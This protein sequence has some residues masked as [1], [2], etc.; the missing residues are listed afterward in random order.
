MAAWAKKLRR[1]GYPAT[2]RHQVIVTALEGW[3]KMCEEEDKGV[4]PVHRPREWRELE[5]RLEKELKSQNWH[6]CQPISGNMLKELKKE[7]KKFE[8]LTWMRVIVMEG[9]KSA[10]KHLAK[11][12]PLKSKGCG[13]DDCFPCSSKSS[14]CEKNGVGY[15]ICCKTCK[16]AGKTTIYGGETGKNGFTRGKHQRKNSK[17]SMKI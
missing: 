10:I 14:K 9:A 1:S 17:I 6:K 13:R 7:C 15:S 16:L 11:S 5:R 8:E 12:E 4:W 3:D 2:V